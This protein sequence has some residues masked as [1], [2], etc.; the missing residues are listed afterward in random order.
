MPPASE[1]NHRPGSFLMEEKGV[2]EE[3]GQV[4]PLRRHS[5]STRSSRGIGR[6]LNVGCGVDIT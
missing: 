3:N 2:E 1:K 5:G 4:K 6:E